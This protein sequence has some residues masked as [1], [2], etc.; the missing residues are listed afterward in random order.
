MDQ[1]VK[2]FAPTI[3]G[4]PDADVIDQLHHFVSVYMLVVFAVLVGVR[5][6][7]VGALDCWY[8]NNT[9]KHFQEHVNTYCWTGKLY[10]FPVSDNFSQVPSRRSLVS[11]EPVNFNKFKY[12]EL[13]DINFYRWIIVIYLAQAMLFIMPRIIWIVCNK[14]SGIQIEK[15]VALIT[16][17][18]AETKTFERAAKEIQVYLNFTN[19]NITPD[20]CRPCIAIKAIG[21]GLFQH[22]KLFCGFSGK[23]CLLKSHF[24][25]KVLLLGNL[26][27]Q[28]GMMES[29]L[30]FNYWKYGY[31]FDKIYDDTGEAIDN[32]H[33]PR[34]CLC[35]FQADGQGGFVQCLLTLNMLLGKLFLIEW[36]WLIILLIVTGLHFIVWFIR[37]SCN[38]TN[39]RCFQDKLSNK[40]KENTKTEQSCWQK[41]GQT[42]RKCCQK[43]RNCC[44]A[45]G[46][47]CCLPLPRCSALREWYNEDKW[48]LKFMN[49]Y[50][51]ALEK[52]GFALQGDKVKQQ[53]FVLHD[54]GSAGVFILRI[55]AANTNEMVMTELV[56]SLWTLYTE[57]ETG[58]PNSPTQIQEASKDSCVS[59]S[60]V[61]RKSH[62]DSPSFDVFYSSLFGKPQ[63]STP[64]LIAFSDESSE[65][66]DPLLQSHRA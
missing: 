20:E 45:C 5:T 43:L 63:L 21:K 9:A 12:E 17:K 52:V 66:G 4:C 10:K 48:D 14:Y 28:L 8:T 64:A 47:K 51:L 37:V 54:L 26:I 30:E 18:S 61:S 31:T 33:F 22:V 35:Y 59:A 40:N 1:L 60:Q 29:F 55:M 38:L 58:E 25:V 23:I 16:D 11:E 24:F 62:V 53:K 57:E 7:T 65:E 41:C 44:Q 50:L 39:W 49:K 15:L 3:Q 56:K 13:E 36:Y 32:I 42:W 19:D 34:L 6:F 2:L 27:G 46:G